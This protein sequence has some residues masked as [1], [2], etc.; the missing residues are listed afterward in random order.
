MGSGPQC[1]PVYPRMQDLIYRGS[2]AHFV[3]MHYKCKKIKM[4][5]VSILNYK[6]NPS[7]ISRANYGNQNQEMK[8][9][10]YHIL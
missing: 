6:R 8:I 3:I 7:V 9:N 2:A 1:L 5:V 10:L 4:Y